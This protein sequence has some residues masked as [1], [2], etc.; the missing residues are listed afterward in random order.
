M[1]SNSAAGEADLLACGFPRRPS[2]QRRP[3]P[4]ATDPPVY[5]ITPLVGHR[6]HLAY[7]PMGFPRRRGKP[8]GQQG[9]EIRWAFS[10]TTVEDAAAL[11]ET[12]FH[13][14]SPLV[15]TFSGDDAGRSLYV[16][17]RWRNTRGQGGPWSRPLESAVP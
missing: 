12:L 10:E 3:A 1:D 7:Y 4:I 5:E 14:A 11:K 16:A 17:M 2:K 9:V 6:L 8:A 13:T 15:L